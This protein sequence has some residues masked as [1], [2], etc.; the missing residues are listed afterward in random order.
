MVGVFKSSNLSWNKLVKELLSSPIVTNASET[1]TAD[2]NGEVIAVNRRDH[3][4]AAL[5]YRLGFVDICGLDLAGKKALQPTIAEIVGGLPS[6]GYGRGSPIPVLPNQPTLFYRAGL[7]NIC[8]AVANLV[9]DA[10]AIPSMPN[11]KSW[12]SMKSDAAIADF[13]GTLMALTPSDPRNAQA[14]AILKAHF[15][16]AM[17]ASGSAGNALKSTF[18]TACLAPSSIGLGL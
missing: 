5:D 4:C 13:V 6:D 9:I 12:T 15:T 18:I 17:Q 3:L 10:P 7:E 1:K 14:Q 11:A 16:A 2:V 8:E